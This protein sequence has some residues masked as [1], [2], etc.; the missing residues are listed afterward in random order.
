M[1][2]KQER[3]IAAAQRC[4]VVSSQVPGGRR[5]RQCGS[6]AEAARMWNEFR[7]HGV[8]QVPELASSTIAIRTSSLPSFLAFFPLAGIMLLL[9]WK[10]TSAPPAAAFNSSCLNTSVFTLF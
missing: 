6:V 1:H 10:S 3:R 5:L 9:T 8:E 2:G 7:R 4:L